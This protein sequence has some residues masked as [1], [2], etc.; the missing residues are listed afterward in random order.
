MLAMVRMAIDSAGCDIVSMAPTHSPYVNNLHKCRK[1]FLDG[2]WDFWLSMD[3]DNAPRARNP[4]ELAHLGLDVVGCP[5]PVFANMKPGED[6]PMYWN[7]M[8]WDEQR[9]GW[10]PH[11][12]MDGLQEV[13]A[14][15]S[16]CFMVRRCVMEAISAPFMRIW[17]EEG[18]VE[19]GGD[20]AFCRRAKDLGFRIWAHYDYPCYHFNEV[21]LSEVAHAFRVES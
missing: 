1:T 10:T 15:G 5:T 18:I 14:I 19:V 12:E 13:D 16:G 2:D 20:Y 7:A 9:Q 4:L 8:D 17:N 11:K 21:E 3:A 6:Y